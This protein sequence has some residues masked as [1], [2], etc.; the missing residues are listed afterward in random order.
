MRARGAGEDCQDEVTSYRSKP[1]AAH[2]P[3]QGA[4]DAVSRRGWAFP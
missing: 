2:P 3:T 1:V 4:D